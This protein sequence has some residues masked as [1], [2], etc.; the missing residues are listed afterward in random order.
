MSHTIHYITPRY[1][2]Y[3]TALLTQVW[4]DPSLPSYTQVWG[5]PRNT[6]FPDTPSVRHSRCP[7]KSAHHGKPIHMWN[8]SSDLI[9][10][11]TTKSV[12]KEKENQVLMGYID[13][14]IRYL[15]GF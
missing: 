5:D 13:L 2:W 9:P 6:L 10:P 14:I 1:V 4:G 12:Q 15:P 8:P 7:L 3:H 11:Q